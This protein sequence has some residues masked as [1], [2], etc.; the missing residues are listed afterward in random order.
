MYICTYYFGLGITWESP[1][2]EPQGLGAEEALQ[3]DRRLRHGAV[4]EGSEA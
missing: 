4:A 1:A 3:G 2:I